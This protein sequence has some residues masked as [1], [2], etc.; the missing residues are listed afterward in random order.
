[1]GGEGWTRARE[2]LCV[3][4]SGWLDN[5]YLWNVWDWDKCFFTYYRFAAVL[6]LDIM[7]YYR[8]A[9]ETSDWSRQ[10]L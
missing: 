2:R 4:T 9:S 3:S 1:M 7:L 10:C 8:N 5:R 6:Y